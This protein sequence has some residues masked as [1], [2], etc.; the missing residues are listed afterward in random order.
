MPLWT[1]PKFGHVS[2][3]QLNVEC[4]PAEDLVPNHCFSLAD[5]AGPRSGLSSTTSA[6]LGL[7]LSGVP[8][9]R[10]LRSTK[11]GFLIVPVARTRTTQNPAISA[12]GPSLW[13]RL[14]LHLFPR[15]LS[16]P[17]YAHLK[18]VLFSCARIGS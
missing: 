7:Q 12:V 9:R 8:G 17:F 16:S 10:P 6:A 3:Y 11:Q 1:H 18:T 5:F 15:V 14:S 2:T 4:A 13:K